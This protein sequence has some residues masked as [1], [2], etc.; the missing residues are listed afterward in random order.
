MIQQKKK[1][2]KED[3]DIDMGELYFFFAPFSIF[4]CVFCCEMNQ[5][6]TNRVLPDKDK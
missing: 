1:N 5:S 6:N 3:I 2:A 4:L